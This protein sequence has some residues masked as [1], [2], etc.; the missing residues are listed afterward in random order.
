MTIKQIAEAFSSHR[1]E[2]SSSISPRT[3]VGFSPVRSGRGQGGHRGGLPRRG[4]RVRGALET[5]ELTRF[6]S[7]AEAAT[8]AVDVVARYV[9][10][11]GSVSIVS[12][13]DVYEADSDGRLVTITSYAVELE[14]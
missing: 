3:P 2:T 13:A 9:S 6:V 8:A 10:K 4:G 11:D 14:A 1:F 5:T 12:S 7:I